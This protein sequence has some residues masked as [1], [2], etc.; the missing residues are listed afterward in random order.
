VVVLRLTGLSEQETRRAW[1]LISQLDDIQYHKQEAA[2]RILTE[3]LNHYHEVLKEATRSKS[4]STGAKTRIK[5]IFVEA[6][7][8]DR[9]KQAIDGRGLLDDV[10][11]LIKLMGKTK[12][13]ARKAVEN[14]LKKITGKDLGEDTKTWQEWWSK[15]QAEQSD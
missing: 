5:Q 1:H 8:A 13:Q 2:A 4:L 15:K 7:E 9:I 6:L 11:Y 14:R 3:R 10:D 12:G